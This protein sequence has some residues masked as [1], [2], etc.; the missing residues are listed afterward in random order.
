MSRVDDAANA[1]P[2]AGGPP[3]RGSPRPPPQVRE[4]RP[5]DA[6]ALHRLYRAAYAPHEDPHRPPVAGLRDTV[7]DVRKGEGIGAAML[8]MAVAR[9]RDDGFE[10]AMLDTSPRT[11]GSPASTSGTGSSGGAWS[12]STTGTSGCSTGGGS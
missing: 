12:G 7:E 3:S 8:E 11:R 6:E 10:V 2:R 5:E 4:A 1:Q 9:A